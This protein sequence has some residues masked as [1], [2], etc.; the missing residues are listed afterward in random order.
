M[1]VKESKLFL[2]T[3]TTRQIALTTQTLEVLD[4]NKLK[5][6]CNTTNCTT[7]V[8]P[9][10][11]AKR[12][13]PFELLEHGKPK[14]VFN[15]PTATARDDL[16]RRIEAAAAGVAWESP[17]NHWDNF[18]SVAR[19]I[20]EAKH[21]N[22]PKSNVSVALVQRHFQDMIDIYN[23]TGSFTNIDD[24]YA[25]FLDQEREYVKG[26]ARAGNFAQT[27]H[28]L[29]PICY[30][31]GKKQRPLCSAIGDIITHCAHRNCRAPL[32]LRM[33]FG[34]HIL[35]QPG[36]CP[37]CSRP[38]YYETYKILDFLE[39]TP[40]VL[41]KYST[42]TGTG[43]MVFTPPEIPDDGRFGTFF[44]LLID[45][46]LRCED[47]TMYASRVLRMQVKGMARKTLR[48]PIGAFTVDL[49]QGMFRQLDFIN[50]M[51]PHTEYWMHPEVLTA[52]ICRYEQF[53]YLMGK[54]E[55]DA[56]GV[57]V[58]MLVPT[59]DIDLVWHAHQTTGRP[60]R[61]YSR[62]VNKNKMIIDH[63]DTIPGGDLAKGY[64]DTFV[65][66]SQ[67]YHEAYSSFPPSYEAWIASSS[68]DPITRH[69]LRKKWAKHGN[70]PS[71]NNRFYGVNETCVV[72]ALPYATAVVEANAVKPESV[73]EA[74]PIYITVIGTPV[75]DGRVRMPYSAQSMMMFDGGL[76]YYYMPFMF[77]GG[78][79]GYGYYGVGGGCGVIG[80]GCA[81]IGGGCGGI[82]GGCGGGDGGG[83]GGGDGGGCGSG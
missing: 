61:D 83:C 48:L 62:S 28:Q 33:S 75:M 5:F 25:Y 29:H 59:S 49:V 21:A 51:V 23:V 17:S 19:R 53:M 52:S 46:L 6:A 60:Y 71:K 42:L 20:N 39:A 80:S 16:L 78:C 82:G 69:V 2:A 9:A 31:E 72:E 38:L 56:V 37:G 32:P 11:D 45:M 57:M 26:E 22:V 41:T 64:A 54:I 1:E 74:V 77:A 47:G 12:A 15:A 34:L 68:P 35:Q 65:L 8:L 63:D 36:M 27:V 30:A 3:W 50:K 18:L 76:P 14:A 43:T 70:V 67:T 24:L 13:F 4:G 7:R 79:G 40:S 58:T 44:D 66:W 55:T 73:L 81:G 10:I